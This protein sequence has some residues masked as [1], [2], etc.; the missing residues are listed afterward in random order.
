MQATSLH[1]TAHEH[2]QTRLIDG[3][4][5]ITQTL[6]LRLVDINTVDLDTEVGK[7]RSTD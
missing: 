7:A 5:A 1:S 6:H 2:I 4:F 3:N